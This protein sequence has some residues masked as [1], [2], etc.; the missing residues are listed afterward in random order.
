[1]SLGAFTLLA[2][3]AL[4]IL[5][6]RYEARI[7][8]LHREME[9]LKRRVGGGS[10][11]L[12]FVQEAIKEINETLEHQLIVSDNILAA[13]VFGLNESDPQRRAKTADLLSERTAE[14]RFEISRRLVLLDGVTVRDLSEFQT[15]LGR[16]LGS[17]DKL[18]ASDFARRVIVL[19]GEG[20]AEAAV[21]HLEKATR[22]Q[23]LAFKRNRV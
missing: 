8:G 22:E 4:M 17:S 1:M 14:S 19:L 7:E 13:V 16:C 9:L 3:V 20:E 18:A 6:A 2:S 10:E 23:R 5:G 12:K 11:E 21:R 15:W